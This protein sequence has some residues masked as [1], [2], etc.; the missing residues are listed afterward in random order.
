MNITVDLSPLRDLD[1]RA[2]SLP[3]AQRAGLRR[4]GEHIQ[5]VMLMEAGKIDNRPIP[6]RQQL[7]SYKRTKKRPR[8]V[9]GEGEP[10]WTRTGALKRAIQA[11]LVE[12]GGSEPSLELRVDAPHAVSREAMGQ[13]WT[14]KRPALG[15]IRRNAFARDALRITEPQIEPLFIDGFNKEWER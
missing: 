7:R 3:N 15:I 2:Q 8:R 1:A 12:L 10:A 4:V 14:P 9:G 6:T 13:D 5:Q 11:P